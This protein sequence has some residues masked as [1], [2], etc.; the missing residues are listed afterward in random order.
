MTLPSYFWDTWPSLMGKL[1][2]DITTTR[3]TQSCIPPG[4][5][6][7]VPA[8]AGVKVGKSLLS[9]GWQL[10][11]CDPIWHVISRSSVTISI[12]SC[13]VCFTLLLLKLHLPSLQWLVLRTPQYKQN[14]FDGEIIMPPVAKKHQRY[15]N[16]VAIGK[17]ISHSSSLKLSQQPSWSICPIPYA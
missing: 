1:S 6:N 8:S 10:T 14:G 3:S 17:Y 5:L 11:L 13:C 7:R 16:S 4:S 2:W 12:T 9:G 15:S